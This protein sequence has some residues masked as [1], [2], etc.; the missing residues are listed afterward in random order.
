M[1]QVQSQIHHFPFEFPFETAHGRKTHQATLTLSLSM[2]NWKGYGEC[3][4][5]PYYGVD[6][7]E[8]EAL[9]L[10]HRTALLRYAYNGPERFWHFLHHLLPEQHFLVAA[11]DIASWDMFARMK[12]A[13]LHQVLGLQWKNIKPSC[14]TIGIQDTAAIQSIIAARP[15]PIY[16]LKVNG[17]N[18]LERVEALR[19]YTQAEIW[20][21]AN[22][23]WHTN[24]APY[25]I[26][27]LKQLGVTMVEQPFPVGEEAAMEMLR[28][29]SSE[30]VFIADESCKT[31][32]DVTAAMQYFDGV[33]IKL[34]K[35]AGIT[36]AL[37]MMQLLKKNQKKIMIGSMCESQAGANALVHFIPLV[38]YVDIDGPLLLPHTNPTLIYQ[39]GCLELPA[40]LGSGYDDRHLQN[41]ASV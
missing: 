9:L 19:R 8:L 26:K 15:S 27:E 34:S 3:T 31:L 10:K 29:T 18:D 23:S 28:H 4:S 16:K 20:I 11:L 2:G 7:V 39:Q 22:A 1:L 25:L 36:P 17:V 24:D 6:V 38:D 40:G 21:D 35:C 37:Q 14:Y 13:K 12:N 41:L 33:N 30:I 32:E 5:I